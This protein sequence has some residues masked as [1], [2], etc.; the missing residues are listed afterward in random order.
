MM[1]SIRHEVEADVRRRAKVDGNQSEFAA[2]IRSRGWSFQSLAPVGKGCPDGLIGKGWL[3]AII[4]F[5]IPGE[6]LN[7]MQVD[8]HGKWSGTV[9]TAWTVGDV[10]AIL[11]ELE[12]R[13]AA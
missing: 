11:D 13:L 5:K 12:S 4:E 10:A 6:T 8:W 2:Y 7:P 3:H 1:Q 9:Y